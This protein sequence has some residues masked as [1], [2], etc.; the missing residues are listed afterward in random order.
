MPNTTETAT[1]FTDWKNDLAKWLNAQA[2]TIYY[3]KPGVV[4]HVHST[5]DG[6]APAPAWYLPGTDDIYIDVDRAEVIDPARSTLPEVPDSL[7]EKI[8]ARLL[9]LLAHEAAHS[10]WSHW[11]DPRKVKTTKAIFD[12]LVMFEELRIENRAVAQSPGLAARLR[13]ALPLV[14]GGLREATITSRAQAARGWALI[15]GRT[16]SGIV[17]DDELD[18]MD[19]T[20]RVVLGDDDVDVLVDLLDEAVALP[21]DAVNRLIEIAAEW[22]EVVGVSEPDGDGEGGNGEGGCGHW[23]DEG[24]E[25]G[26][27]D[28]DEG[29][30]SD[31]SG[32]DEDSG[33]DSDS[34]GTGDAD[35]SDDGDGESD[36]DTGEGGGAL[37][38]FDSQEETDVESTPSTSE[39]L[40]D[41][42]SE[43]ML[44][45]IRKALD[46]IDVNWKPDLTKLVLSDP[47]AQAA[48]VFGR[49]TRKGTL[50]AEE[51]TNVE[52]TQILRTAR[53]LE[54][55]T[56]PAITKKSVAGLT[57]PGRLRSREA[58]RQSAER[59]TGMMTT[60][61]P[62]RTTKRR[63]DD[64]KPVTVGIMT[65]TSGSMHWAQ[66]A[67]AQFAYVWGNA[68]NRI[69]AR[70]AAV[71]FGDQAHAV[72]RPGEVPAKIQVKNADGGSEVFDK[73]AAA[74]DGV[75]KL[76]H[77]NGAAKVL[78]V[79]SDGHLV[80]SRETDR[81]YEWCRRFKAGG[82]E[83]IWITPSTSAL[84]SRLEA[85][86]LA[87]VVAVGRGYDTDGS[88]FDKIQAAALGA[89]ARK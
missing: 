25:A 23:T 18:W 28:A 48:L 73:G 40:D 65:D 46:E 76:S 52:R 83:V 74:I 75:L 78:V 53:S 6:L 37:G 10:A 85:D 82:T 79:V 89:L 39:P 30:A 54:A 62:W 55:M 27:E 12:V 1:S 47:T 57:P 31:E 68:A 41:E 16:L 50:R 66:Q 8:R 64:V 69:G 59:A 44:D 2:W 72:V 80:I 87:T 3:I 13:A 32:D 45:A 58:V 20:A 77:P 56:L 14:I 15:F 81:A 86:G 88:M 11:L 22:I 7:D 34:E 33:D 63:H 61:R 51:P 60:A 29:A 19:E 84:P 26:E 36:D 17:N 70:T 71:T 43:I 38:T 42:A 21:D 49:K 4:A 35:D 9:G 67:V 24:T 5:E